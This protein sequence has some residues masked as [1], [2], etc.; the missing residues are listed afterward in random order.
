MAG[1]RNALVLPAMLGLAACGVGGDI[2]VVGADRPDTPIPAAALAGTHDPV[3]IALHIPRKQLETIARYENALSFRTYRCDNA[4]RF[5][6]PELFLGEAAIQ[7]DSGEP[8]SPEAKALLLREAAATDKGATATLSIIMSRSVL[9]G[10]SYL[11]GRFHHDIRLGFGEFDGGARSREI[12]LPPPT[13]AQ[14]AARTDLPCTFAAP[15][16]KEMQTLPRCVSLDHGGRLRFTPAQFARLPF[17]ADG[18]ARLHVKQWYVV[19]REGLSAP[20]ATFDNGPEAFSEGVARSPRG[21]QI[22][23]VDITL[24]NRFGLSDGAMPFKGGVG[25]VCDGCVR[26]SDGEHS[27]YEGGKWTCVTP[28]AEARFH[29][30]ELKPGETP[31]TLCA[32]YRTKS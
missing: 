27:W 9:D 1:L 5:Y 13:P 2:D 15:G 16:T 6:T 21:S 10:E 26:R 8:L 3:M 17:E 31:D 22:G 23:Y 20:I 32:P 19:S 12:Q 18:L 30:R 25:A 7:R 14:I 24:R 11:C 28:K 29:M 4:N